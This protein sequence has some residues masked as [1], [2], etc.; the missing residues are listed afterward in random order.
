MNIVTNNALAYINWGNW[1]ADCSRGCGFAV[2]L[3]PHQTSFACELKL[4]GCGHINTVLW[5]ENA[6]ELFKVLEDRSMPKTR[7]WFPRNHPLAIK[8]GCPH[9]QTVQ[10]LRTETEENEGSI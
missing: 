2:S 8:A 1:V 4:G 7:N 10:E 6:S 3:E 9:G 5:P